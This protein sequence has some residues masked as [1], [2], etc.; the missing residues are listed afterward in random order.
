[1]LIALGFDHTDFH[2]RIDPVE[3][4]DRLRNEFIAVSQ[5]ESTPRALLK[6]EG[7]DDGFARAGG[8]RNQGS[9]QTVLCTVQDSSNG[10]FLIGSGGKPKGACQDGS[11]PSSFFD[12]SRLWHV[13]NGSLGSRFMLHYTGRK[14]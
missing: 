6:Q 4:L 5:D 10:F 3:F 1:M 8:Q 2:T 13:G 7:K 14:S 11:H 12:G 9:F